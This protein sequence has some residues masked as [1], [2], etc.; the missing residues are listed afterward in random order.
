MR[1]QQEAKSHHEQAS[2]PSRT[3]TGILEHVRSAMPTLSARSRTVAAY[4][5]AHPERAVEAS[6]ARL[7]EETETSV[8][9][10]VRLCQ[11][12]G[13]SGIQAL[14]LSLAADLGLGHRAVLAA[15]DDNLSDATFARIITSLTRT[16]ASIDH[17]AL[18]YVAARIDSAQRILL[19]ASGT[20]QA[21]A[22]E[23]GNWLNWSGYTVSYP[24]DS[25]TQEAVS[26]RLGP[27]EL[28]VAISHSGVTHL[29]N[30]P[31]RI[32]SSRGATTIA[33]TSFTG[34]PLVALADV[35]IIAGA[36]RDDA[37]SDD[38]ASR[39]VHHA[40]LQVIRSLL[41]PSTKERRLSQ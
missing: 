26:N 36:D 32:A 29:T 3:V 39:M 38:M 37:R 16:A 10:V 30:E 1:I 28:C 8:G 4:L 40:V 34:T 19:V 22:M 18:E 24:M 41:P 2:A 17:E 35:A 13:L 15:R 14:K 23:F 12:L 9:T 33:L 11:T 20:S 21:L 5:L 25:R 7:A 6:A 31:L 27:G